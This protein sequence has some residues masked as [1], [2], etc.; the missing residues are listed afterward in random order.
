MDGLCHLSS[1]PWVGRR[2]HQIRRCRRALVIRNFRSLFQKLR[3]LWA[4]ISCSYVLNYFYGIRLLC[5]NRR[6]NRWS[7]QILLPKAVLVVG[8]RGPGFS[9]IWYFGLMFWAVPSLFPI[10]SFFWLREF[11]CDFSHFFGIAVALISLESLSFFN[12]F[13]DFLLSWGHLRYRSSLEKLLANVEN[14]FFDFGIWWYGWLKTPFFGIFALFLVCCLIA[15]YVPCLGLIWIIRSI[16]KFSS[17]I[18]KQ[19]PNF[20]PP[21]SSLPSVLLDPLLHP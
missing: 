7:F 20:G 18:L 21:Y 6:M 16:L 17:K 15:E 14:L 19:Y 11:F 8:P 9:L 13:K 2:F 5:R 12:W 4:K 1:W 3:K 10:N